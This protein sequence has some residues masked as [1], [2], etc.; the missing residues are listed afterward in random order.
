MKGDPMAAKD[1]LIGRM[2]QEAERYGVSLNDK[3][4]RKIDETARRVAES[5]GAVKNREFRYRPDG[6]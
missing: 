2:R 4:T 5:A 1:A 6:R 3:V